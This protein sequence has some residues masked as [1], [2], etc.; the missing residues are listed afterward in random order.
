MRR[1]PV[2]VDELASALGNACSRH[3][4]IRGLDA[5]GQRHE[6]GRHHGR[7]AVGRPRQTAETVTVPSLLRPVRLPSPSVAGA[8]GRPVAG[9]LPLG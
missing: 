9:L 3:A 8:H 7:R 5:A 1:D 6:A 2:R 4:R